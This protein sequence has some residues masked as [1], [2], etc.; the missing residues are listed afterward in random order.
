MA[1]GQGLLPFPFAW[2]H[3]ARGVYVQYA[4]QDEQGY[5]EWGPHPWAGLEGEVAPGV[6][7]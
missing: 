3:Q 4:S 6:E 5:L 1:Q 2:R 7:A